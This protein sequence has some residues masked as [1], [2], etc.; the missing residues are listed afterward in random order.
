[1][2]TD[3]RSDAIEITG[4][5]PLFEDDEAPLYVDLRLRSGGRSLQAAILRSGEGWTL[6]VRDER[7]RMIPGSGELY[8]TISDAVLA[9]LGLSLEVGRRRAMNT[10]EVE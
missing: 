1:M 7:G 8:E 5:S 3:L 2:D 9:A 4:L 6:N 10:L